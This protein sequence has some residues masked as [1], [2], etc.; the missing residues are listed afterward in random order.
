VDVIFDANIL[1]EDF[2]FSGKNF[3][4]FWSEAPRIPAKVFLPKVALDETVNKYRER[5]E[6]KALE[7][8]KLAR[9][10][11]VL[12]NRTLQPYL[13]ESSVPE[14]VKGYKSQIQ[15]RLDEFGV[16][17]LPYPTVSHEEVVRR[18]LAR[19]RPFRPGGAGYRDALIWETI[20]SLCHSRPATTI[21]FVTRNERDFG[22][23]PCVLGEMEAELKKKS[24]S[25][26][27]ISVCRGLDKFNSD[28]IMPRLESLVTLE[29]QFASH[30]VKGL[31]I[32]GW[33]AANLSSM[34][35]PEDLAIACA[36]FDTCGSVSISS[37]EHIRQIHVIDARGLTSGEVL[38]S[39]SAEIDLVIHVSAS[40]SDW[41]RSEAVRGFFGG[42]SDFEF[43]SG[44]LPSKISVRFSLFVT[45]G[46]GVVESG[47]LDAIE[48]DLASV[49]INPL[50]RRLNR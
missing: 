24:I 25:P 29:A 42:D 40:A 1:C 28:F 36:G 2:L 15:S 20:I 41:E 10:V 44:W 7:S 11:G 38:I 4:I 8:E 9:S 35:G 6:A 19:L 30:G 32:H 50:P 33:L 3:R 22:P 17:V 16:T 46:T 31:V 34:L 43:V 45:P 21:I 12:I 49:E 23:G 5:L 13:D 14:M 27:R 39:A 37:I 18:D 48:G 47:E 26:E